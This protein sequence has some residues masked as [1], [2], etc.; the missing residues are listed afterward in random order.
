MVSCRLVTSCDASVCIGT[1]MLALVC[2]SWTST[3][4]DFP[5][6]CQTKHASTQL[7]IQWKWLLY[8]LH[9]V[10]L[11][12]ACNSQYKLHGMLFVVSW[13]CHHPMGIK[14][15][16]ALHYI[17]IS[18]GQSWSASRGHWSLKAWL[19][20][21]GDIRVFWMSRRIFISQYY[22]DAALAFFVLC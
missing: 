8:N 3:V 16:L 21:C 22:Y 4:H 13:S 14:N 7:C 15:K 2:S 19:C 11:L 20:K 12:K 6:L 1:F 10:L 18:G 5:K 9:L 17:I